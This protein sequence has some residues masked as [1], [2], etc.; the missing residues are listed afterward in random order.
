MMD[1]CERFD[2]VAAHRKLCW[3]LA[4][5][6]LKVGWWMDECALVV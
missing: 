1:A 4:V 5:R 6:E 3:L 2:N